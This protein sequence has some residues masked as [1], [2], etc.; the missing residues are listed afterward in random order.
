MDTIHGSSPSFCI[1]CVC[2]CVCVGVVCCVLS[3]PE[4]YLTLIFVQAVEGWRLADD[5]DIGYFSKCGE[6]ERERERERER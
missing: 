5:E 1:L 3:C 4:I 6:K 2:G